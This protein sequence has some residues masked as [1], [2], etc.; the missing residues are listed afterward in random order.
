MEWRAENIQIMGPTYATL[1][2]P[3]SDLPETELRR[4]QVVVLNDNDYV[5]HTGRLLSTYMDNRT[6]KRFVMVD[7][8]EEYNINAPADKCYLIKALAHRYG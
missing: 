1:D 2:G 6:H 7:I 8:G 3:V 5:E 4:V